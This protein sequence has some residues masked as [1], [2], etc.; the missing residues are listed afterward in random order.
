MQASFALFLSTMMA[1]QCLMDLPLP[2]PRCRC[3]W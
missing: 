3:C 1:L 2:L